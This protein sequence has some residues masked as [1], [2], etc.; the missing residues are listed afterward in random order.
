MSSLRLR[1]ETKVAHTH[2]NKVEQKQALALLLSLR[3]QLKSPE[4]FEAI[5]GMEGLRAADR[6]LKE[7]KAAG[8]LIGGVAEEIWKGKGSDIESHKDVDVMV[9]TR[10]HGLRK[11]EGGIDWWIPVGATI[12]VPTISGNITMSESWWRNM[13]GVN[14]AFGLGAYSGYDFPGLH[15][16]SLDFVREMR[17]YEAVS[18]IDRTTRGVVE[19]DETS[20]KNSFNKGLKREVKGVIRPDIKK[21]FSYDEARFGMFINQMNGDLVRALANPQNYLSPLQETWNNKT[22]E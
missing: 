6:I 9:L 8:V 4:T 18:I 14:L 11:A 10:E 17:F 20:F 16:P 5:R 12:E 15:I 1:L 7:R 13:N 3:L 19:A 22:P 2:L 21:E